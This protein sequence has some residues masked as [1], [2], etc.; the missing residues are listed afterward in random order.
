MQCHEIQESLS[1]YFDG[2]LDPSVMEAVDRHLMECSVC[3]SEAEDLKMIVQLVRELPEVDP[4]EGFRTD[5]RAKLERIPAPAG[6]TGVIQK[7]SRGRWSAFVALAASFLLVVGTAASVWDG[8]P[9]KG[10]VKEISITKGEYDS[11]TAPPGVGHGS[12]SDG[13]GSARLPVVAGKSTAQDSSA[14]YLSEKM[15]LKTDTNNMTSQETTKKQED[16]TRLEAVRE[17]AVTLQS[18]NAVPDGNGVTGR[19][20][21][22]APAPSQAQLHKNVVLGLK[23]DDKINATREVFSIA[24]RYGGVAAVL[25]ETGEKELL[26]RIP[27]ENFEKVISDVSKTGKITGEDYSGQAGAAAAPLHVEQIE[28]LGK[29]GAGPEKDVTSGTVSQDVYAAGAD[30]KTQ[31]PSR[32]ENGAAMATIRIKLE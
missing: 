21:A 28:S 15:D 14:G 26:L 13:G 5:L 24:R 31:D 2:M 17:E 30:V 18:L 3:R 29:G 22:A 6:K 11:V 10:G 19:G 12:R 9:L 27:E 16:K 1:A 8:F 23:V 7:L 32:L 25:P 20:V 4:P